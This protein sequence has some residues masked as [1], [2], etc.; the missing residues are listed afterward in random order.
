MWKWVL[1]VIM[2]MLGL[3]LFGRQALQQRALLP[4]EIAVTATEDATRPPP[5]D[6]YEQLAY[7]AEDIVDPS[8]IY[9][10]TY[11]RIVSVKPRTPS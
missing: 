6:F 8:I 1:A 7:A 11:V 3:I 10:G 4:A 9:D 5:K 2:L